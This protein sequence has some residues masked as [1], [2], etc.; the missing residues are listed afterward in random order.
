VDQQYKTLWEGGVGETLSGEG[1]P[2][3][4]VLLGGNMASEF[5]NAL[6]AYG[7][8]VKGALARMLNKEEM[9]KKFLVKFRADTS[10]SQ[11]SGIIGSGFDDN[12]TAVCEKIFHLAHTIKGVAANLGLT[13]IAN[14]A[15]EICERTRTADTDKTG[16]GEHFF[17]LQHSYEELNAV[18]D[19]VL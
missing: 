17:N 6:S 7:A 10:F 4:N 9:Y 19:K 18:L 14:E 12:D 3:E 16:I 1:F 2:H 8:D 11:L 5:L 13:A 15:S